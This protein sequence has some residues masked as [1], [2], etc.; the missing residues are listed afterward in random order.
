FA[1][2]VLAGDNPFVV[3][4]RAGVHRFLQLVFEDPP[5]VPWPFDE[6]MARQRQADVDFEAKVVDAIGR[7]PETLLLAPMLPDNQAPVL[8]RWCARD[9]VLDSRV[10]DC[11][12]AGL[13]D[14]RTL[15]LTGCGQTPPIERP[16]A[17][18]GALVGFLGA[19]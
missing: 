10:A 6:A 17:R 14:A 15:T 1:T 12:A 2:A 4:D 3:T 18:A 13:R 11:Y 16:G 5:R 7:G 9:R 8:L 19:D